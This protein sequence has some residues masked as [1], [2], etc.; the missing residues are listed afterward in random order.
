MNETRK[1]EFCKNVFNTFLVASMGTIA[2]IFVNF[3]KIDNARIMLGFV[4]IFV[5]SVVI[6]I[7]GR[8]RKLELCKNVFNTFLVA[9]MGA[10][11]Y[12]FVNFETLSV[13]KIILGVVGEIFISI[14]LFI[15]ARIYVLEER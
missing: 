2:Y 1:L 5:I 11:A 8:T 13:T 12:I 6:V 9:C 15:I 10:I 4:A 3:D 14:L 7:V